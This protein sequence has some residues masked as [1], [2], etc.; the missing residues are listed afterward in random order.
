MGIRIQKNTKYPKH[1]DIELGDR[2]LL[3]GEKR[4]DGVFEAFG[5]RPVRET[6]PPHILDKRFPNHELKKEKNRNMREKVYEFQTEKS[7]PIGE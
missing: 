7:A 3:I 2:V 4:E 6:I 1:K 5:I